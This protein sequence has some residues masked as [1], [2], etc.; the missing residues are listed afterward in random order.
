MP[1]FISKLWFGCVILLSLPSFFFCF[2]VSCDFET[3][4]GDDANFCSHNFRVMYPDIGDVSCIYLPNCLE[5][6]N[7]LTKDLGPPWIKFSKA[8]PEEMYTLIM[9]DPDVPSRYQPIYR[10]WRHWLVSDIPGHVLLTGRAVTGKVLSSY[11]QPNP[12]ARTRYHR[13]QFLLYE[14]YQ[15]VSPSL[16]PG[17]E[18]LKSWDVNA[19]VLRWIPGNPIATTQF[20]MQHPEHSV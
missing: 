6:Q 9:V 12:P 19:F 5:Y 16:L 8:K 13:Y 3:L 1:L 20:M 11:R 17:E 14:Q 15:G 7:S 10:F 4:I 2:P 18:S